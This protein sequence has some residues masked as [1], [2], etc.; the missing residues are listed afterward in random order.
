MTWFEAREPIE[1]RNKDC[2]A[3]CSKMIMATQP[4]GRASRFN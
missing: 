3:Y 4:G 1:G 2:S